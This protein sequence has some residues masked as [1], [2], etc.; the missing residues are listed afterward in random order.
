M[1]TVKS[2][3]ET[4]TVFF[5]YRVTIVKPWPTLSFLVPGHRL[6]SA[7]YQIL[8]EG[9]RAKEAAKIPQQRCFQL[10]WISTQP[11]VGHQQ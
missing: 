1:M 9:F 5:V 8:A 7:F 10:A 3:H 11:M 4:G 6:R 2:Q